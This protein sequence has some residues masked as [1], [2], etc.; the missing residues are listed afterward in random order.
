MIYTIRQAT[1]NDIP[2]LAHIHLASKLAAESGIIDQAF[3]D[4]KTVEQYKE[5]WVTFFEMDDSTQLI[6][7]VDSQSAGFISFGQLRNPP[8]GMSKI[9]PLYSS[10]IYAI[11][12]HPDYF[13]Q[14]VGKALLSE[15]VKNLQELKH[16][17]LCLW[18]LDK[19]KRGCGFYEAM[20]GQ[21]VGKKMTEFGPS[22]AKEVCYAWRNIKEILD[23]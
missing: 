23:K 22:R 6:L 5:K 21:R 10:E 17:S 7:S 2:D 1:Q 3:L 8:A 13:R 15:A 12:V 9:R 18:A 11:Y 14:G 4:A 16:Q 19:N 20:G